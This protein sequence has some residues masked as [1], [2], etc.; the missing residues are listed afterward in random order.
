[1]RHARTSAVAEPRVERLRLESP[2]APMKLTRRGRLLVTLLVTAL[3]LVAFSVG[4]ASSHAGDTPA[5]P[6]ATVVVQEG[7]T[8]W[9]IAR[10]T[11][12]EGDPRVTV[13][14]ILELNDLGSASS[15]R[16]GQQLTLP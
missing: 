2:A 4:R 13:S 14:R 6:R 10:R 1:V 5:S 16:A 7:D 12:P 3:L 9:E 8:L 15:V 11:S